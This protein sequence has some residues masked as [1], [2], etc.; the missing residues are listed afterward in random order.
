MSASG[1]NLLIK[2]LIE[3]GL[4]EKEARVY[5]ALIE[6]EVAAVSEI[7]ETGNINRSSTY[8]V[9]DSL[10]KKGMV[11]TTG[12]K[13]VQRYFAISPDILLRESEDKA[14][15]AENIKSRIRD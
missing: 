13:K 1:N 6:L 4:G 12:D 15:K 14:I 10:K 8:V 9:L 11:S 3:F 7:G 5:L 2:Q